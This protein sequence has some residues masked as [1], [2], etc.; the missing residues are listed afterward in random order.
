MN[1]LNIFIENEKPESPVVMTSTASKFTAV[2]VKKMD[3]PKYSNELEMP[4]I[5]FLL[6]GDDSV[7]VGQS[8]LD[9][10]RK[11]I[12]NTHSG[13]I[14]S[15]WHTVIGFMCIDKTIS[16]NELLFMENAMCEY[17]H[18]NY[19][20]CMTASPSKANCNV[21]YRQ[22]HYNLTGMQIH[23]CN[24][25]LADIKYY[26]SLFR[27]SIFIDN[28]PGPGPGPGPKPQNT[29]L[30]Y[31]SNPGRDVKGTAE[32]EI[33]LGHTKA[34]RTVL[35]KGSKISA[36]V[37]PSAGNQQAVIDYRTQLETA[38]KI[39]N[40]VLQEDIPFPSQSGAGRFLNGTSFDGN[41][42]WKTVNGDKKLKDLL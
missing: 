27:P 28:G 3:V 41:G 20:K 2:R 40:R 16:S 12:L 29:E 8:G 14:D 39:V 19:P 10:V 15:T 34:R 11:R 31:F 36:D 30:F 18:T 35:K 32:I 17:V 5:Y 6:I 33:N 24:Q 21:K 25:Y 4:G 9:T 38:G 42:S 7:Y 22:T 1:S 23:A 13:N 37:M 26:I